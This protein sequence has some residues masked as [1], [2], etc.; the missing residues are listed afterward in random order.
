MYFHHP[1]QKS[2]DM[3]LNSNET[4]GP[5]R[6]KVGLTN[7]RLQPDQIPGSQI[8]PQSDRVFHPRFGIPDSGLARVTVKLLREMQRMSISALV[9][10]KTSRLIWARSGRLKIR[11]K[12][13]RL[14]VR[15][16]W[17]IL[18][19]ALY[20]KLRVPSL[21]LIWVTVFY[22]VTRAG[23]LSWPRLGPDQ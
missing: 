21:G 3:A 17:H 15:Q 22:P 2:P 11:Q 19:V 14:S 5:I 6:A 7:P 23:I 16:T 10:N 4:H 12:V 20:F 1:V 13:L 8:W 18:D 9:Q